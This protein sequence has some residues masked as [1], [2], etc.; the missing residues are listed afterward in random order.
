[1]N[2]LINCLLFVLTIS[3]N[4]FCQTVTHSFDNEMFQYFGRWDKSNTTRYA[5]D[6]VGSEVRFKFTGTKLVVKMRQFKNTWSKTYVDVFID[7]VRKDSISIKGKEWHQI[8]ESETA[9]THT[10]S[11]FKRSES[12]MGDLGFLGIDLTGEL[13]EPEKVKPL[14]FL[15]GGASWETGY[16][17]IPNLPVEI[18]RDSSGTSE[19]TNSYYSYP[20]IVSRMYE[21]QYQCAC[22]G[23]K[24]LIRAYDGDTVFQLPQIFYSSLGA[25]KKPFDMQSFVPDVVVLDLGGNDFEIGVPEKELFVNTYLTFLENVRTT[26]PNTHI[27]I[28]DLT[29][30]ANDTLRDSTIYNIYED[31]TQTVYNTFSD[32][33]EKVY[34]WRYA[35]KNI[36]F[37]GL[38]THPNIPTLD[39]M[40]TDLFGF[41]QTKIGFELGVEGENKSESFNLMFPNP[42]HD[43]LVLTNIN[44]GETVK[45]CD[46]NG[47]VVF[48]SKGSINQE[49]DVHDLSAGIWL[50][51]VGNQVSRFIKD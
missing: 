41:I 10:V 19:L 34:L 49:L 2:R 50:L 26:Y 21:A 44:S 9:E 16:G 38:E 40:A 1:M 37:W 6:F 33:D 17:N 23:G 48:E 36:K 20:A 51:Q 39:N 27:I 24:G 4:V 46:L 8:F 15:F 7:G 28:A 42:V 45:I 43:K 32:S 18:S 30:V 35:E 47:R 22:F 11:I 31:Y 29:L 12:F 25:Q 5:S 13:L 14:K 3:S